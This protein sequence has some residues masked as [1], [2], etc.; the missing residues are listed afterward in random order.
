MEIESKSWELTEM[1]EVMGS[2]KMNQRHQTQPPNEAIQISAGVV[3]CWFVCLFFFLDPL[4]L[5]TSLLTL[6]SRP[7]TCAILWHI[8]PLILK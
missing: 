4:M 8:T 5:P 6:G 2:A 7:T 3:F 1:G